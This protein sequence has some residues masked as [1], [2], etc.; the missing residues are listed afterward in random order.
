MRDRH[1]L[2]DFLLNMKNTKGQTA[3]DVAFAHGNINLARDHLSY[4]SLLDGRGYTEA[5]KFQDE[6]NGDANHTLH[7]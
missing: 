5:F 7:W 3:R 6:H 1:T 2:H 4:D